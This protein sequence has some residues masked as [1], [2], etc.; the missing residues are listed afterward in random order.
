VK[1][2]N[3]IRHWRRS[4]LKNPDKPKIFIKKNVRSHSY[5]QFY[6][7]LAKIR[8]NRGLLYVLVMFANDK[9][10]RGVMLFRDFRLTFGTRYWSKDMGEARGCHAPQIFRI[11]SHFVLWEAVFQKNTAARL[12]SNILSPIQFLAGYGSAQR[13][14]CFHSGEEASFVW[15]LWTDV[16]M[17]M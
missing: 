11:S 9:D 13:M 12:K 5:H 14:R 7:V 6:P 4:G 3:F 2:A 16:I 8:I 1:R 15:Y 17:Q 10:E